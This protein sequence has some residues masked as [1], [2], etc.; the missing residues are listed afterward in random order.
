[1]TDIISVTADV[2]IIIGNTYVVEELSYGR[3]AISIG[4]REGMSTD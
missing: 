4:F 2:G 1:V 3:E